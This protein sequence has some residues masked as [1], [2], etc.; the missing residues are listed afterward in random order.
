MFW[1]V[2]PALRQTPRPGVR[3]HWTFESSGEGGVLTHCPANDVGNGHVVCRLALSTPHGKPERHCGSEFIDRFTSGPRVST[4]R[5]E[6]MLPA[7]SSVR[8]LRPLA[9]ARRS[10]HETIATLDAVQTHGMK[11]RAGV[12]VLTLMRRGQVSPPSFDSATITS[13]LFA[14]VWSAYAM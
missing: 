14:A 7:K 6:S 5:R 2:S 11:R 12:G 13:S 3:S 9:A 4:P 10:Y 8:S 1:Q